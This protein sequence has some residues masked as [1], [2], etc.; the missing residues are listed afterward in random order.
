M[1]SESDWIWVWPKSWAYKIGMR[2]IMLWL[3]YYDFSSHVILFKVASYGIG[4]N[5]MSGCYDKLVQNLVDKSS[6]FTKIWTHYGQFVMVTGAI[7]WHIIW[8][9]FWSMKPD[10]MDKSSSA[11]CVCVPCPSWL[12]WRLGGSMT[13][14]R[15]SMPCFK[16]ASISNLEKGLKEFAHFLRDLHEFVSIW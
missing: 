6:R 13:S 15:R 12:L 9:S 16:W 4:T 5:F 8:N 1:K 7:F 2:E 14:G 10:E 11:N 3:K